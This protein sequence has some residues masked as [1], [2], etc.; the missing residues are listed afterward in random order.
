MLRIFTRKPAGTILKH[1]ADATVYLDGRDQRELVI[2]MRVSLKA[3]KGRTLVGE[4]I[5]IMRAQ[6]AA[7]QEDA[8]PPPAPEPPPPAAA[9]SAD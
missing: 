1:H 4:V 3:K 8:T 6:L 9:A 5:D 2:E 7:A